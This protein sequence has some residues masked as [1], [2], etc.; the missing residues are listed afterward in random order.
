MSHPIIPLDVEFIASKLANNVVSHTITALGEITRPYEDQ[1]GNGT[2]RQF[3]LTYGMRKWTKYIPR[4]KPE[5]GPVS[6]KN[7]LEDIAFDAREMDLRAQLAVLYS[8]QTGHDLEVCKKALD[9]I[10]MVEGIDVTLGLRLFDIDAPKLNYLVIDDRLVDNPNVSNH[11]DTDPFFGG[12]LAAQSKGYRSIT[13][14]EQIQL[15]YSTPHQNSEEAK[16]Y[17]GKALLQISERLSHVG[18]KVAIAS[19][20]NRFNDA[21]GDIDWMAVNVDGVTWDNGAYFQ[22]TVDKLIGL[23]LAIDASI[24]ALALS[25]RLGLREMLYDYLGQHVSWGGDVF[26][27]SVDER[28]THVCFAPSNGSGGPVYLLDS[29]GLPKLVGR[30]NN[31]LDSRMEWNLKD[32]DYVVTY[33]PLDDYFSSLKGK[34]GSQGLITFD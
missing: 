14:L 28:G 8:K 15:L 9:Y 5:S 19:S 25:Q 30:A 34:A 18:S 23:P 31:D 10:I 33:Q 26:I 3:D 29:N 6:Y 27:L 32:H 22:H 21:A 24:G 17:I 2:I 12:L 1:W 20:A 16:A 7:T 11:Y 4:D 13:L